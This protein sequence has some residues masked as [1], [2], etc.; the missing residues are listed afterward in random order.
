MERRQFLN[1][2]AGLSLGK[3]IRAG[4]RERIIII[5][6]GIVGA[7]ICYRLAQRGV[8]VTLLERQEPAAGATRGSFAWI[9][10]SFTKQPRHYFNLNLQ[11]ILAFRALHQELGRALP[12]VWSGTVEWYSTSD[13]AAELRRMVGVQQEWGYP[14]RLLERGALERLE[15]RVRFQPGCSASLAT[16]E[17]HVD[18][19]GATRLLLEK[20][21]M[22]GAEIVY[23]CDVRKIEADRSGY[24]LRTS[25]GEMLA[26]KLVLACGIETSRMAEMAGIDI[27]LIPAPG[28]VVK[29]APQ[30]RTFSHLLVTE[31]AHMRRGLDGRVV[32]GDDFGP[33]ATA[34]HRLLEGEQ[35]TFPSRALARIHGERIRAQAARSL[36]EIGR[37][38]IEEVNLCWRPMPKDGFPVVGYADGQRRLYLAVMHSGVTLGPLIGSLATMEIVDGV[39]V[40]LL[41]PYRPLR[42]GVH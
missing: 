41:A 7:S 27:P 10:A 26:E 39:T 33:P 40:D 17:G 30:P 34:V 6:G 14:I 1:S 29:T 35:R 21:R 18:A 23:P 8:A 24:L 11:G 28:I 32:I 36:P 12:V 16:I 25:R 2:V 9:N 37:A 42:F 22:F 5:G 4:G 31:E 20:A 19:A 13:R 3:M 38:R 15:P